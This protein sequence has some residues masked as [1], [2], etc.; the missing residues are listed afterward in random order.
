[1]RVIPVVLFLAS[2]SLVAA[3]TESSVL[4]PT[5][6]TGPMAEQSSA[7]STLAVVTRNLYVGTDVDAVISALA[8]GDPAQAFSALLAAVE[9]L[10]RTDFPA[11]ATAIVDEIARA[12]PDAVGLQEVSTIDL[13]VPPAGVNIHQ[14]F[15]ST[16]QAELSSRGLE[17]DVAAS[18]KNIEAVPF[19]GVSLVDFDVLLVRRG[20]HTTGGSGHNFAGSVIVAP[21]V[22]LKRGW[23][24][25]TLTIG[26][27]DITVASTH[28]ES[29][30]APGFNL[31]R[32]AQARELV[33]SL[34][35]ARPTVLMGDL[36]DAPGSLMHA[37]LTD[38]GFVDVWRELR[39]AVVGN[40]CC[41]AGDL[42]N[43]LPDLTQRIDYVFERGLDRPHSGLIGKIDR[44]GEVPADRLVGAVS[45]IWASDHAGLAA[46]LRLQ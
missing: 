37:A 34:D 24:T 23:V 29:G 27:A 44:L 32:E 19:D 8:S 1:M 15:L 16:I 7:A 22:E 4:S 46:E 40:T 25:A 18:V 17:Y 3:C 2:T 43:K 33:L 21:G 14:N 39:P 10:G 30:N 41:H 6:R 9:T 28:L 12:N 20:I 5:E 35:P 13:V 31:I 11:R 36:N 42:S 38:A 26:G 45:Q